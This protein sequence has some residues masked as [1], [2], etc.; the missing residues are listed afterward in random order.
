MSKC[1]KMTS[2]LRQIEFRTQIKGPCGN[3]NK[4]LFL[5]LAGSALLVCG[6]IPVALSKSEGAGSVRTLVLLPG[7]HLYIQVLGNIQRYGSGGS[8]TL[9]K[10]QKNERLR[11]STRQK[12]SACP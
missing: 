6:Q 5:S 2:F 3:C 10:R 4:S 9:C 12:A 7:A 8:V 1:P 11:L